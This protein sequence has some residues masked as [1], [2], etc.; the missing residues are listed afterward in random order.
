MDQRDD[1]A[2]VGAAVAE[3]IRAIDSDDPLPLFT[4]EHLTNVVSNQRDMS[5]SRVEV[6]E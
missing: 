1:V 5:V 6:G 3:V 4:K 2:W